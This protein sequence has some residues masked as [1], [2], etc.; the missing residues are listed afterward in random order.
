MP[1]YLAPALLASLLFATGTVLQKHAIQARLAGLD[2]VGVLRSR[3][4]FARA[5]GGNE[6]WLLGTG[7]LV[8]GGPISIQAL[9]LGDVGVVKPLMRIQLVVVVG[10]GIVF[11]GE[12]LRRA[13]SWGVALLFAGAL[14]LAGRTVGAEGPSPETAACVSLLAVTV[15]ACGGVLLLHHRFPNRVPQEIA[16][17]VAC[18][19]LLGVGD[20]LMKAGTGAANELAGPFDVMDPRSLA[21]LMS[22]PLPYLSFGADAT[23]FFL[24]QA[25]LAS[26]RVSVLAPVGGVASVCFTVVLGHAFLGEALE[27]GRIVAVA[28]VVSGALMLARHAE[29]PTAASRP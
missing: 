20:I 28:A 19:L 26:S 12:R 4:A 22:T 9:A 25:A 29:V 5:M 6:V 7:L 14:G 16:L 2:Y 11:L 3:L 27:T 10:L 23:S 15:C 1:D 8:A 18:G 21:A 13:E 17:G 24:G